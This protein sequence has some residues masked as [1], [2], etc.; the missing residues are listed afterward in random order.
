MLVCLLSYRQAVTLSDESRCSILLST[1]QSAIRN[2]IPL[3]EMK[4]LALKKGSSSTSNAVTAKSQEF[5]QTFSGG[6]NFFSLYQQVCYLC[7]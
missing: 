7:I 3:K 6:Y 1:V 5:S 4:N 2:Y